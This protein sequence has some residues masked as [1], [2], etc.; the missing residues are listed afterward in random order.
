MNS[1]LMLSLKK[2]NIWN[3]NSNVPPLNKTQRAF[4][5][6]CFVWLKE[7][8]SNINKKG[9]T[10]SSNAAWLNSW[11]LRDFYMQ[12]TFWKRSF[13]KFLIKDYIDKIDMMER[14]ISFALSSVVA[15]YSFCQSE[16]YEN[17]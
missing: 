11:Y 2:G 7:D 10:N 6:P 1:C 8:Q 5:F 3:I 16:C 12:S 9:R 13:D 4:S 17:T 14:E 15:K